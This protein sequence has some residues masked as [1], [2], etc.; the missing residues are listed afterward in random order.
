M[1]VAAAKRAALLIHEQLD[2]EI[3]VIAEIAVKM[4]GIHGHWAIDLDWNVGCAA[5][6][7]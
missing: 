4:A 6:L 1:S 3:V 5:G 2:L 7:L